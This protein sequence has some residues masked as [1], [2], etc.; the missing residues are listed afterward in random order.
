MLQVIKSGSKF[1][2]VIDSVNGFQSKKDDFSQSLLSEAIN[3]VNNHENEEMKTATNTQI[4]SENPSNDEQNSKNNE[5]YMS[6]DLE[7]DLEENIS[8]KLKQIDKDFKELNLIL[9]NLNDQISKEQQIK[10]TMQ[11]AWCARFKVQLNKT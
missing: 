11:S 4:S 6:D 5:K 2:L 7:T 9:T 1:E 8:L 3:N 10:R